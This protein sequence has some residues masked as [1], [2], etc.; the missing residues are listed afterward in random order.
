MK[1]YTF[2]TLCGISLLT[3]SL[4]VFLY[5][6]NTREEYRFIGSFHQL[7]I[8][9]PVQLFLVKGLGDSIHIVA[10]KG[11]ADS[12]AT[13]VIDERLIITASPNIVHERVLKVMVSSD[14]LNEIILNG[15]SSV[16]MATQV[17]SDTFS[18][19]LHQSSE[20]RIHIDCKSLQV[21]LNGSSNVFMAGKTDVLNMKI[22]E[23]SDVIAYNLESRLCNMDIQTP[24]SSEGIIRVNVSDTLKATMAPESSRT[25][26][27]KGTAQVIA[28][29]VIKNRVRKK[30]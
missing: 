17:T 30:E 27:Y 5:V 13:K 20:A 18:I 3:F 21:E 22:L 2:I 10:D 16:E 28:S 19:F 6:F 15:P 23:Y 26:Y 8:N 11:L 25:V 12:I 4:A 1:K 24:K 29:D 9:G 14:H 7:E